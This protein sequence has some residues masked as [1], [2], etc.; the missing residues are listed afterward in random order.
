[1]PK[2]YN[3]KRDRI[4]QGAVFVGRPSKWG[5]RYV[6]GRDGTRE[7]VIRK[8]ELWL[9]RHPEIMAE[10]REKLAGRD[11]VCFCAPLPCHGDIILKYANRKPLAMKDIEEEEL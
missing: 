9:L 8:Y 4:P 7:E 2:V 10:M 3:R 11:V 6:I 1:V 5:N